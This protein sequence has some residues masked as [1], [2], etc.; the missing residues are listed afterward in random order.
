MIAF[1]DRSAAPHYCDLFQLLNFHVG[2]TLQFIK[3]DKMLEIDNVSIWNS[4][5]I[6]IRG[7]LLLLF[8]NFIGSFHFK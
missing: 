4:I 7:S 2:L 8:L 5:L 3:V 6:F 1:V